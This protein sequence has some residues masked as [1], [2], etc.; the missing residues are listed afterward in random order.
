MTIHLTHHR[1]ALLPHYC[2]VYT[3]INVV[4]DH[5][6]E[7]DDFQPQTSECERLLLAFSHDMN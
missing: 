5:R 2:T 3:K 1:H 7:I 4:L 6:S